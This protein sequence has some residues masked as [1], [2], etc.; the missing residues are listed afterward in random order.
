MGTRAADLYHNIEW[1]KR[2]GQLCQ[3]LEATQ[4]G[5]RCCIWPPKHLVMA[6]HSVM[7][8]SGHDEQLLLGMNCA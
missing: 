7:G 5:W 2:S 6:E 8:A 3:C 4:K 1:Q